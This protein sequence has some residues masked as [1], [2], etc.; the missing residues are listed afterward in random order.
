M[1]ENAVHDERVTHLIRKM[2]RIWSAIIIGFGVIIFVAE[3]FEAF[4]SELN[5]YPWYENLIPVTLFTAV[6]GLALAWRWEGPGGAITIISLALNVGI[7]LVTGREAVGMVVLILT[8]ILIPGV[9]FLVCWYRLNKKS[10]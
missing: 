9:L 4:S 7:Y 10:R 3:I 2:A 6:V 1:N 8:P 5:P